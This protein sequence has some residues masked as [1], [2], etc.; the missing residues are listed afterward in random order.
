MPNCLACLEEEALEIPA[1]HISNGIGSCEKHWRA[2]Q[3]S[4]EK[5][6]P[7]E[8]KEEGDAV[9]ETA[10]KES[11]PQ[12]R[13]WR[14][15]KDIDWASVQRDRDSAVLTLKQMAEKYGVS[16]ATINNKTKPRGFGTTNPMRPA[17]VSPP[18]KRLVVKNNQNGNSETVSVEFTADELRETI[19]AIHTAARTLNDTELNAYKSKAVIFAKLAWRL[20]QQYIKEFPAEVPDDSEK[21]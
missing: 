5:D 2:Q 7:K 13:K 21:E 10:E 17:E 15:T 14:S 4:K 18:A 12:E 6:K 16:M 11:R 9:I 1:F 3:A 19:V 8:E 20:D